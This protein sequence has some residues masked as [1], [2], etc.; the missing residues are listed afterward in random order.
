MRALALCIF[1]LSMACGCVT[2]KDY[3]QGKCTEYKPY[4][5]WGGHM[6][7][8]RDNR[9]CQMCSCE[10]GFTPSSSTGRIPSPAGRPNGE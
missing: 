10:A 2:T 7:C 6:V 3:G 8:L 1:S 9:G 5:C 4:L